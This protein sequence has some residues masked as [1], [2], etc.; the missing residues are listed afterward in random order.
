MSIALPD[1]PQ[2]PPARFF[3]ARAHAKRLEAENHRLR[4]TLE[5]LDGLGLAEIRDV[6]TQARDAVAALTEQVAT[7]QA[8]LEQAQA[9]LLDV[10]SQVTVQH[11]G[12]YDFE[13]PAEDSSHL[14]TRLSQVRERIHRSVAR[15]DAVVAASRIRLNR[16][17]RAVVAT[18]LP[19]QLS[20][21]ALAAYDAEAENA[22]HTVEPGRLD[23]ARARLDRFAST[24]ETCGRLVDLRI[25][26]EYH[27]LRT[28]ELELAAQ[29]AVVLA[30]EAETER[31]HRAGLHEA[32]Q[33]AEQLR[34]ERSL[35][36]HDREHCSA[37]LAVAHAR[38]D[39]EE[40]ERHVARLAELDQA[41]AATARR[42]VDQRAGYVYVIS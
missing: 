10:R 35:L 15:G 40:T 25:D 14:A 11:R 8:E 16:R 19:A 9:E 36:E 12:L 24:V 27:R 28:T 3:G 33:V 37:A 26:A 1:E 32:S 20:A 7:T 4:T 38:G 39:A 30:S 13:H 2:H 31:A 23:V 5:Q 41:L 34:H 42:T 6:V 22:I 21:L 18:E 29:H 17:A